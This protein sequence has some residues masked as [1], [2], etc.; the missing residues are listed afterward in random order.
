MPCCQEPPTRRSADELFISDKTVSTHVSNL[1][2][3]TGTTS[4]IELAAL[5][6][7]NNGEAEE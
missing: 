1:L 6:S 5:A 3:K 2:K 4:R 7:R